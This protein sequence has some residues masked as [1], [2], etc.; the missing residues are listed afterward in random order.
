MCL[1]APTGTPKDAIAALEK[2]V[3][4]V[5]GTK[6]YAKYMKKN[7]LAAFHIPREEAEKKMAAMYSVFEPLVKKALLQ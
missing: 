7:N 6:G 3:E 2:A 4:H 1:F 5:A